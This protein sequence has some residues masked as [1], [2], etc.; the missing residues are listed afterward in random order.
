MDLS[1]A[2]SAPGPRRAGPVLAVSMED[3][4]GG[5][6]HSGAHYA[7]VSIAARASCGGR[8]MG[9]TSVHILACAIML[10][11]DG[12]DRYRGCWAAA[13]IRPSRIN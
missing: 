6:G 12:S 7:V 11:G 4:R 13:S 5:G 3:I 1:F 2:L 9:R 8:T 10:E